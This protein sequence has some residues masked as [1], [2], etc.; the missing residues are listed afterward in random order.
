MKL[1]EQMRDQ[2]H[3]AT[4]QQKDDWADEVAQ[5]EFQIA[6][7][8]YALELTAAIEIDCYDAGD[9]ALNTAWDAA[10]KA[11]RIAKNIDYAN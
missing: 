8:L 7:L 4:F 10:N 1:S 11:L 2:T 5:L 3:G 6:E 9:I